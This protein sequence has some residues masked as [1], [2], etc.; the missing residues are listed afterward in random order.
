MQLPPHLPPTFGQQSV[1][2]ML[3]Q[4]SKPFKYFSVLYRV[5]V[6]TADGWGTGTDA[7]V[8]IQIFGKL[9]NTSVVQ[10]TKSGNLFE[11][12]Q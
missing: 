3:K 8:F 11:S 4:M 1:E 2:R 9:G 12:G 5:S 6:E 10:L 7:D